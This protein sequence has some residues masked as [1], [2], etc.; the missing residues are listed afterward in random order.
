MNKTDY[1]RTYWAGFPAGVMICIAAIV[2]LNCKSPVVGAFLFS[3][4]LL[5]ICRY[6]AA[7]Y[8]GAVGYLAE[9]SPR[10]M[11]SYILG[12]TSMLLGNAVGAC[13]TAVLYAGTRMSSIIQ[14]KVAEIMQVKA[15]DSWSSLFLLAVGCGVLMFIA[16]NSYR[17]KQS[18]PLE[19]VLFVI[20]CVVVFIL[21]GFEHSIADLSYYYLYRFTTAGADVDLFWHILGPTVL[22]NAVGAMGACAAKKWILE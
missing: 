16:V 21:S 17:D 9:T 7:L 20:F 10:N 15:Q 14:P 13:I 6:H 11:P 5:T 18:S 8:T 1:T 2:N 12:L 3:L 22:G 4:G 19:Q